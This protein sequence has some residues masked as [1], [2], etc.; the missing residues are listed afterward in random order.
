MTKLTVPKKICTS[1]DGIAARLHANL[2]PKV[3][4]GTPNGP[5]QKAASSTIALRVALAHTTTI[6]TTNVLV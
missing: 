5:L 6:T 1:A 2:N 3:A 4:N